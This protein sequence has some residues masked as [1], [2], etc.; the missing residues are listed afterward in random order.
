[1]EKEYKL[2]HHRFKSGKE[3]FDAGDLSA[4]IQY[5]IHEKNVD[6]LLYAAN[7]LMEKGRKE[8]ADKILKEAY[9][10]EALKNGVEPI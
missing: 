10:L 1:M 7:V 8:E 5:Y 9:R 2:S 3:A 4:A 6:G